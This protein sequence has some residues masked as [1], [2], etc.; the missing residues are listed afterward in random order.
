MDSLSP[1]RTGIS[2]TVVKIEY[3][4]L[5][6]FLEF[7]RGLMYRVF[8]CCWILALGFTAGKISNMI[9]GV[10]VGAAIQ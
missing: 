10:V 9:F 5:A 4:Q 6:L 7:F 2:L 1:G 8:V 3:S